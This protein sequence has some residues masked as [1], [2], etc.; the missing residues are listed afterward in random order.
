MAVKDRIYVLEE[1]TAQQPQKKG[2]KGRIFLW[3]KYMGMNKCER[4]KSEDWKIKY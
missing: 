1:R 3:L 4:R 2:R